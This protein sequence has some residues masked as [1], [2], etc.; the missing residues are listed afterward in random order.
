MAIALESDVVLGN[1]GGGG[2]MQ[3]GRK[4]AGQSRWIHAFAESDE[5]KV[6]DC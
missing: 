2:K 3:R 6:K 5:A 4:V 1:R